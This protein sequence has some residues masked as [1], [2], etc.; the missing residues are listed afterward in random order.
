[1]STSPS[2]AETRDG[3]SVI[4]WRGRDF[5]YFSVSDIAESEF[6]EFVVRWRD[7]AIER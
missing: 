4:R 6:S 7:A 1:V 5:D 2:L 3:Y